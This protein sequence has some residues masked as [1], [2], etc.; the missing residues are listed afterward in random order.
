MTM[1]MIDRAAR[2]MY[3][4]VQPEW[5]WDDPDAELLRQLYSDNARPAILAIRD[6]SQAMENAGQDERQRSDTVAR[7]WRT[8]IDACLEDRA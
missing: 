6:P 1:T 8:M 3:A 2:A 4:T 7:T 5:S